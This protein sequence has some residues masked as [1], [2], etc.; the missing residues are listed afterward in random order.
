MFPPKAG[1]LCDKKDKQA[2]CLSYIDIFIITRD[3]RRLSQDTNY[4]VEKPYSTI[5][6][7][8]WGLFNAS[9]THIGFKI[10]SHIA[11]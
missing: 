9:G 6:E 10:G 2:L 3:S 4:M 1:E 5:F 8:F 11:K 7:C